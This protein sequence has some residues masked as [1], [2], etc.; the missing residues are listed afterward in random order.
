[1][2]IVKLRGG[3]GNQIFQYAIGKIMTIKSNVDL[4]IDKSSFSETDKG[5]KNLEIIKYLESK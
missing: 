3:F 1:M 2:I 4:Y 5:I